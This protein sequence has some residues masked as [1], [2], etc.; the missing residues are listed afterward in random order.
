M[1]PHF[2]TPVLHSHSVLLYHSEHLLQGGFCWSLGSCLLAGGVLSSWPACAHCLVKKLPHFHMGGTTQKTTLA[3]NASSRGS[4]LFFTPIRKQS[5]TTTEKLSQRWM[6]YSSVP[7]HSQ[8]I[9]PALIKCPYSALIECSW[10]DS[11]E[12]GLPPGPGE[13][14]T[15]NHLHYEP[16]ALGSPL[17][18]GP[19]T[20]T[21]QQACSGRILETGFKISFSFFPECLSSTNFVVED[22]DADSCS[23]H[24]SS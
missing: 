11:G 15:P 22:G 4:E 2:K 20:V 12:G 3:L 6:L 13:E 21:W 16:C 14:G 8:C 7:R 5:N 9:V 24:H 17:P 18:L 1:A 19:G 23:V 10:C